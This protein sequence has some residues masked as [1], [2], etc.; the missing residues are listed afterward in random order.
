MWRLFLME[1]KGL[2]LL[3]TTDIFHCILFPSTLSSIE[4]FPRYFIT[5]FSKYVKDMGIRARTWLLIFKTIKEFVLLSLDQGFW[6]HN[7]P[8]GTHLIEVSAIGFLF[9]PVWCFSF[10]PWS[11]LY[12]IKRKCHIIFINI[13]SSGTCW[14]QCKKPRQDSGGADREPE[15]S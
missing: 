6:S 3:G 8:A 10:S 2:L 13:S 7:V 4:I 5:Y 14:Y 12:I 1:D 9:S 11:P 15:G